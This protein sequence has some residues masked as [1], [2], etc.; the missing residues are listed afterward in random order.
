[1]KDDQEERIIKKIESQGDGCGSLILLAIIMFMTMHSCDTGD[2]NTE[3]LK[4][5][6]NKCQTS[7]TR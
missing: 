2:K 7:N 3:I 5:I 6:E 4:R 1:M